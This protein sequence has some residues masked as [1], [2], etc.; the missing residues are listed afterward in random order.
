V[1]AELSDGGVVGIGTWIWLGRFKRYPRIDVYEDDGLHEGKGL[2][3]RQIGGIIRWLQFRD[4]GA[5]GGRSGFYQF[6]LVSFSEYQ[7]TI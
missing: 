6:T 4:S 7:A 1:D 2:S 5:L 3:E